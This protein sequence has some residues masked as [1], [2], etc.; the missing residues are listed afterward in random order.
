MP[1]DLSVPEMRPEAGVDHVDVMGFLGL[2]KAE[3]L[4]TD[5]KSAEDD[6]DAKP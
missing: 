4:T 3:A 2:K 1:K 6:K 5:K